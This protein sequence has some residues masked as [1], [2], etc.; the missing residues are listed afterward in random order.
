LSGIAFVPVLGAWY[1]KDE[2]YAYKYTPN[3]IN[4]LTEPWP[5]TEELVAY[6]GDNIGLWNTKRFRRMALMNSDFSYEKYLV[7]ASLWKN[8]VP[9]M[10]L[11]STFDLPRFHYYIS[12]LPLPEA[13]VVRSS[14]DKTPVGRTSWTH[15]HLDA[16]S[17]KIVQALGV[18]LSKQPAEKCFSNAVP[19]AFRPKA[20]ATRFFSFHCNTHVASF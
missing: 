5:A 8:L 18:R 4:T 6:L 10:N 20:R 11:Y 16:S 2:I 9:T 1:V 14:S 12:H 15:A 17:N 19:F 13:A 7:L 3:L